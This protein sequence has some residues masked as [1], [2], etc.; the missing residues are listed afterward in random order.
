[1]RTNNIVFSLKIKKR[2]QYWFG[3]VTDVAAFLVQQQNAAHENK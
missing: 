1:M 3:L 2:N